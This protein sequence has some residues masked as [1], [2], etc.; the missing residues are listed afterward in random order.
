MTRH[1]CDL[2]EADMARPGLAPTTT[3]E[4][5]LQNP[6][7]ELE[8]LRRENALLREALATRK[9]IEL[10][11]ALLML[12]DGLSEPAAHRYIQKS[13]MDARV[14]MVDIARSLIP[15]GPGRP[16]RV[17]TA[18]VR[19]TPSDSLWAPSRHWF[20]ATTPASDALADGY[21]APASP[22][23][24]GHTQPAPRTMGGQS[25]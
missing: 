16:G 13:S 25:G 19:R 22:G 23:L 11:K 15:K 7:D 5:G 8:A 17:T 24:P 6:G 14:P 3:Q 9:V 10:A 1:S 21:R 2:Q 4:S 12:R 18:G 20:G